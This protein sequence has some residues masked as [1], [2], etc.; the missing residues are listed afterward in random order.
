[1]KTG[2]F[3]RIKAAKTKAEVDSLLKEAGGWDDIAP[4]TWRK[5]HRIARKRKLE[6]E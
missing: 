4:R 6:L 1:M 3:E 2:I 5:A